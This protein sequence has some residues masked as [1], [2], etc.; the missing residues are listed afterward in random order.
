MPGPVGSPTPAISGKRASRPL[1]QR[2]VDVAG[3][4]VHD[5]AGRLVDDDHVVV[6][7]HDGD[8]DRRVGAVASAST[9]SASVDV[10]RRRPLAA[11]AERT[12]TGPPPTP[13]S[14]VVD[15]L[16]G[17]GPAAPG[18]HRHDPVDALTVERRGHLLQVPHAGSDPHRP[19]GRRRRLDLARTRPRSPTA[20]RRCTIAA[21]ATL[22]TGHH[23]R[24]IEVHDRALQEPA[25]RAEQPVGEVADRAADH[26]AARDGGRA[27]LDGA[28]R[29]EDH[30]DD[31]HRR[32]RDGRPDARRTGG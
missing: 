7:V 16:G 19:A 30:H 25:V 26:Q 28:E 20:P 22:N 15:Q 24:S 18:H 17:L 4:G 10:Q 11:C 3:A 32:Q 29:P 8:L 5:Q 14:P 21:S 9:A 31:D 6:G 2:A 13:T 27:A 23:W 1:H 12:V